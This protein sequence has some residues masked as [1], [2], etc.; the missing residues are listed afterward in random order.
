MER[1]DAALAIDIGGTKLAAA[2]VTGEGEVIGDRRTATAANGDGERLYAD[3][4][5]IAREALAEA[6]ADVAVVGIGAG[7]GGPMAW[8]DGVVSPLYIPAWREFPLRARL[9][10]SFAMRALVDND[11]KAMALGEWWL[12]AGAATRN[13]IGIVVST[14]LGGGLVVDGRLL[15]GGHGHAGHIG[16]VNVDPDGPTCL[17]GSRGCAAAIAA[18]TSIARRFRER[19]GRDVSA[20][21]VAAIAR[22]GDAS[23]RELFAD[24]GRAVGRAIASTAS[25]CDL[26]LAVLGG[27]IALYAWDLIGTEIEQELRA[28]AR[29]PFERALRVTQA[30]L[31]ARAGLVGA[32]ALLLRPAR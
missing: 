20:A 1:M 25:L 9:E 15:D 14:G 23:A 27:S 5:R 28:R 11:A 3:L 24:A 30:A 2:I 17:C 8:P 29:M 6:P 31:G 21:D 4:E 7:C 22:A 16:H 26:E 13:M 32:A 10:R 18:G 12:G 19:T